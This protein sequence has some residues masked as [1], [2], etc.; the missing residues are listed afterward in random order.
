MA[1]L[2]AYKPSKISESYYRAS[3]VQENAAGRGR[4]PLWVFPTWNMEHGG[5]LSMP[6][7]NF[8][9]IFDQTDIFDHFLISTLFLRLIFAFY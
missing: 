1:F 4:G 3:K 6:D 5:I 9:L 7:S 2:R 8:I